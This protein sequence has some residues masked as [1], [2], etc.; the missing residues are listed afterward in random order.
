MAWYNQ[1]VLKVPLN[2]SQPTNQQSIINTS[3]DQWSSEFM[4]KVDILNKNLTS[5]VDIHHFDMNNFSVKL[6]SDSEC[7]QI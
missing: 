2:T 3:I 5:V 7:Q 6:Y 4:T 1:F